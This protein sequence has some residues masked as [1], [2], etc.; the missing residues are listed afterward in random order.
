MKNYNPED[1]ISCKITWQIHLFANKY[2]G[3]CIIMTLLMDLMTSRHA[4]FEVDANYNHSTASC[5][6]VILPFLPTPLILS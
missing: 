1:L 4:P 2:G 3:N 6:L 5:L